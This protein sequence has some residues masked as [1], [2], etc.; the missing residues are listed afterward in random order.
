MVQLSIPD[1]DPERHNAQRATSRS[2]YVHEYDRLKLED[3][4]WPFTRKSN[5]PLPW[6]HAKVH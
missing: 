1:T 3:N 5:L 6:R 2:Y 4:T